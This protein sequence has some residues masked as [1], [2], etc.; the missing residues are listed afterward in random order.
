MNMQSLYDQ[1]FNLWIQ[2]HILLLKERRFSEIDTA[3][4]IEE[5]EDMAKGDKREVVNRLIVL[6]AH[7]LKWQFQPSMR[8]NSWTY[9]ID[10]QRVQI[11]ILLSDM[12]SLKSY[13]SEAITK[14]YGRAVKLA[15]KETKLPLSAFPEQCL[16]SQS[17]L[18]N[19]DF[20][21]E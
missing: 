11:E 21:P 1:D 18:L 13:L 16:Y 5:L 9:S 10:E 15:M 3:H 4:L 17:Q 7:L 20:Y 2:N 14:S 19:E 6:I 12:P 8:G